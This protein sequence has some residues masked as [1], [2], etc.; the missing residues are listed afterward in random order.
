VSNAKKK[1][2]IKIDYRCWAILYKFMTIL[3]LVP[4]SKGNIVGM[5]RQMRTAL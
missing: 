1:N 2:L 5:I 3:M 4:A